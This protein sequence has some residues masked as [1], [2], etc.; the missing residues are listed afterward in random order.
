MMEHA[1]ALVTLAAE[2]GAPAQP[3]SDPLAGFGIIIPMV[4]ILI[5]FFWLS[6]RTQK[7]QERERQQMLDS[8]KPRDKVVTIGGMYGRV[9]EVK[10]DAIVLR[11]DENKDVRVAVLRSAV[12][13]KVSGEEEQKPA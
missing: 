13:R 2:G 7:K 6:S 12:S 9:V 1:Y 5:V 4:L 3:P 11:V 10:D 8:I